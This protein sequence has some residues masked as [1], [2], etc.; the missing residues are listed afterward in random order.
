MIVIDAEEMANFM[1]QRPDKSVA[2]LIRRQA[3]FQMRAA[4]NIENVRSV[5]HVVYTSLQRRDTNV[6]TE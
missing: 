5:T 4:E 1:N 6:K 3:Q 2:Q